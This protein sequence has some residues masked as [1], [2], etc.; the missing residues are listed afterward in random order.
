M[1]VTENWIPFEHLRELE[2]VTALTEQKRAFQ[3]SMRFNLGT[4]TPIASAVLTDMPEP[5]ALFVAED[6]DDTNV[7]AAMLEAASEGRF[8]AWLWIDDEPMQAFPDRRH[9]TVFVEGDPM[10]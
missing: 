7:V 1:L 10:R 6:P 9:K 5:V 8:P 2:V 4:K 3:K